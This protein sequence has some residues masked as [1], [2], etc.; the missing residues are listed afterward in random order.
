MSK[1]NIGDK[2]PE[3]NIPNQNGENIS[4]DHFK[5]KK[6]VIYFYPK[7]MTPGCTAESCDLRDNYNAL[8]DKG[9]AVLGI[10]CDSQ[11][12]HQKFISKYNLPFDLGSDEEQKVVKAYDVWGLKK[13]M[14]KE[15]MG[16]TRRTFI[17]N[18]DSVIEEIITKVNTKEHTTQILK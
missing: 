7:D 14:G 18:E 10:S 9:Y 12:S 17:L 1:L 8:L 5:G 6:L 16:I 3:L 2:A 13:F 4:L 11:K 15:Y